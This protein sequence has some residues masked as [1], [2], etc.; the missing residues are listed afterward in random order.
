MASPEPHHSVSKG[1]APGDGGS[2]ATST[3][4]RQ[5]ATWPWLQLS[6]SNLQG[7]KM[8]KC[9]FGDGSCDM[10]A[11]GKKVCSKYNYTLQEVSHT[12][13]LYAWPLAL[14]RCLPP[15]SGLR[16]SLPAACLQIIR[17][18]ICACRVFGAV[19]DQPVELTISMPDIHAVAVMVWKPAGLD[20]SRV[21]LT[22]KEVREHGEAL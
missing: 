17:H 15:R 18:H 9:P 20:G 13:S 8:R 2:G 11:A 12:A 19:R 14:S 7:G 3:Q 6:A 21:S 1:Q 22:I 16:P 5:M 10:G 4:P